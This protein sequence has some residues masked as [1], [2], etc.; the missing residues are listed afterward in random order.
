MKF[1]LKCKSG[2]ISFY[3]V[4]H[5]YSFTTKKNPWVEGVSQ[6]NEWISVV[7]IGPIFLTFILPFSLSFSLTP[8]K[9][10]DFALIMF[11]CGFPPQDT[12]RAFL[13]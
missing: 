8:F 4:S 5:Y 2:F 10:I 7:R 11:S 12:P 3:N 1:E 9:S 6:R 13:L